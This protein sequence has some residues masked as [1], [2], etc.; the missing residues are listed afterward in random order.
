MRGPLET[1]ID[2]TLN[3]AA[4][5][6]HWNSLESDFE[7]SENLSKTNVHFDWARGVGEPPLLSQSIAIHPNLRVAHRRSSV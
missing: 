3:E 2:V 1:T 7:H 5:M 4:S 6:A